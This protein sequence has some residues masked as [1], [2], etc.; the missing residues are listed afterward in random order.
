MIQ[1]YT[2]GGYSMKHKIGATGILVVKDGV[3]IHAASNVYKDA[4]NNIMEL[5]AAIEALYYVSR[6][7]IYA[8]NEKVEI[9]ADSEY[10]TLGLG[11]RAIKWRDAGWKN[12]SGKVKNQALWKEALEALEYLHGCP[13]IVFTHVDGHSGN[14]WNELVDQILVKSYREHIKE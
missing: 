5:K 4:T 14:E 12:T 11:G 8:E 1:I 10:V 2:D 13:K 6:D 3:V 7:Y 9:I